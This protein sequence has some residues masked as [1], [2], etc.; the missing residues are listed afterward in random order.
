M[1]ADIQIFGNC[2]GNPCRFFGHNHAHSAMI[3]GRT[4]LNGKKIS[5]PDL[6]AGFAYVLAALY[7]EG[8]S[9]IYGLSFLDRGYED[10]TGK[11]LSI[12]AKVSR[13]STTQ[14]TVCST[15]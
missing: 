12:G 3:K 15:T 2:I 4:P 5:I 6:R 1:G 9:E 11:L 10:V 13:I 8:I 14:K 7:A